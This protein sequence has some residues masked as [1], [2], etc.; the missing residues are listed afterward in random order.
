MTRAQVI[1]A[2]SRGTTKAK[3]ITVTRIATIPRIKTSSVTTA[4]TGMTKAGTTVI[5]IWYAIGVIT[6]GIAIGCGDAV[7]S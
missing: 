4:L 5:V 2:T 7:S 3:T 1:K 6:I